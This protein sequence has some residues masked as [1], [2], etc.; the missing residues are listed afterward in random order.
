MQRAV[1]EGCCGEKT[2]LELGGD[3]V[4]TGSRLFDHRRGP[5]RFLGP[6][7]FGEVQTRAD[8]SGEAARQVEDGTADIKYPSEIAVRVAQ[9]ILRF[10]GLAVIEG[11]AVDVDTTVEIL[12]VHTVRPAV[13]QLLLDCAT[14]ERKPRVVEVVASAVR[15]GPPDQQREVVEKVQIVRAH[16]ACPL[17]LQICPHP[18][19]QLR[20]REWFG[21]VVIGPCLKSGDRGILSCAR[22]QRDY[23]QMR[24]RGVRT[25][26]GE[27][28]ETVDP[29][30]HHVGEYQVRRNVPDSAERRGPVGCC[31]H[32]VVVGQQRDEIVTHVGIVVH[33]QHARPAVIA[34]WR[35]AHGSSG[36]VGLRPV[37]PPHRLGEK[38]IRGFRESTW[39]RGRSGT[40]AGGDNAVGRQ[41]CV[42]E[43]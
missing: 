29:R 22:R 13:S 2:S 4:L 15:A 34:V 10:E 8:V 21:Q 38:P 40:S 36:N 24:G 23:W 41:V 20:D 18:R 12:R 35:W 9:P 5:H 27:Q 37:G 14:G 30:H 28:R 26:G 43:R 32:V 17:Q 6:P 3:P 39:R 7:S 31:R 16:P 19:S 25:D 1:N 33:D 11:L 42:T